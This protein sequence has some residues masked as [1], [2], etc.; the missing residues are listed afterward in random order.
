MDCPDCNVKLRRKQTFDRSEYVERVNKCPECNKRFT[1]KEYLEDYL[2]VREKDFDNS[3]RR[4][5]SD[6]REVE[7]KY[8]RLVSALQVIGTVIEGKQ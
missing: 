7:E 2:R 4:L 5:R 6:M 1:S 3:L 8:R